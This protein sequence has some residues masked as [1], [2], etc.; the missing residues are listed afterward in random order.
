M[1]VF[2]CELDSRASKY[3]WRYNNTI[4]IREVYIY[5]FK[6]TKKRSPEILMRQE[7]NKIMRR[8]A[9]SVVRMSGFF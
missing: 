3:M 1:V 8:N 9:K 4:K 2:E 7:L 5:K 6:V